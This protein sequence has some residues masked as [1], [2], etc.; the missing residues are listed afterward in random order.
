MAGPIVPARP[1]IAI[2]EG[3]AGRI[4]R[5]IEM[6]DRLVRAVEAPG[7]WHRPSNRPWCRDRPDLSPRRKM[8]PSR[9]GRDKGS[10]RPKDRRTC[11]HRHCR[12][13][14]TRDRYRS[15][16]GGSSPRPSFRAPR[17]ASCSLAASAS[18]LSGA[19]DVVVPPVRRD[20]AVGHDGARHEAA[21][22]VPGPGKSR[23]TPASTGSC[24]RSPAGLRPSPCR[25][26]RVI[27]A[28]ASSTKRRPLRLTQTLCGLPTSKA[29][30]W[31]SSKLE[32]PGIGIC[33]VGIPQPASVCS[34]AAPIF[35][36]AISASPRL[37]SSGELLCRVRP[38]T[39]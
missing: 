25:T 26:P 21:G 35:S 18:A 31:I 19:E 8:A 22:G 20:L 10:A 4:A 17:A 23:R 38:G 27:A 3:A 7:R 39:A 11:G 13:A 30:W 12:R 36:P 14:R 6:G 2:A 34:V 32:I 33:M 5:G 1:R 37:P 16:R 29:A 24:A 9:L 28:Q 15:W